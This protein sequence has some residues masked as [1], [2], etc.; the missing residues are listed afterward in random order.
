MAKPNNIFFGLEGGFLM[1][2]PAY[3]RGGPS[4][5]KVPLLIYG[6]ITKKKTIFFSNLRFNK[7]E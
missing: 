6:Y 4:T 2:G 3:I 5:P 7:S 1:Y